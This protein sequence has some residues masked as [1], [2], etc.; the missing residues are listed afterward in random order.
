MDSVITTNKMVVHIL[1]IMPHIVLDWDALVCR[2]QCIDPCIFTLYNILPFLIFK[3]LKLGSVL[4][5]AERP[6]YI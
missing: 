4:T 3:Q 1:A 2:N 5:D 6:P